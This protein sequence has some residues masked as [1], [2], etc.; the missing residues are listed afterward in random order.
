MEQKYRDEMD[1]VRR[2]HAA[3]VAELEAKHTAQK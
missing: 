1:K 2:D 3:A